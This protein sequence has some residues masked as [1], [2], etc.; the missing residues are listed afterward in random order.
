ME[1]KGRTLDRTD[2]GI[3]IERPPIFDDL[4]IGSSISVAGICL[5]VAELTQDWMQFDVHEETWKRTKLDTLEKGDFVNLE[6]PLKVGERMGGHI[7]QGHV[8]CVARVAS[9]AQKGGMITIEYPSSLR[10]LIVEKGS[11]TVDGVSLTVTHVDTETFSV[12]LIPETLKKTTL[13]NLK[14]GDR[15]NLEADILGKYAR[16][17]KA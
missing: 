10:G 15:V 9:P 6:R 13:G 11:I 7:V 1:A 2:H 12:A 8:D 14:E 3:R 17:F 16:S 5:T 4:S